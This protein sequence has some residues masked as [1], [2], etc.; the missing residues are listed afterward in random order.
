MHIY[1]LYK[2]Y[3]RLTTTNKASSNLG[4]EHEPASNINMLPMGDN[5]IEACVV[6]LG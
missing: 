6:S 4:H 3:I 2:I 5:G 1:N